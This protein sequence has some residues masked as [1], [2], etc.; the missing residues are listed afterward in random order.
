[1]VFRIVFIKLPYKTGVDILS[2]DSRIQFDSTTTKTSNAAL[3]LFFW[4]CNLA[5]YI[6]FCCVTT[7]SPKLNI[8]IL[9][10]CSHLFYCGI[11]FPLGCPPA[12]EGS[13]CRSRT[14][15]KTR[16][17]AQRL[18]GANGGW[19]SWG[20]TTAIDF[21]RGMCACFAKLSHVF[22]ENVDFLRE[23]P[24]IQLY[25]QILFLGDFRNHSKINF[26]Q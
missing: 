12:H 21:L 14:E 6:Y 26:I 4:Q 18:V 11:I 9:R 16:C 10:Q 1:M 15:Y 5:A 19:L 24:E 17:S 13:V 23:I 25:T 22:C 20:M 3:A 8:Y 2:I 7:V